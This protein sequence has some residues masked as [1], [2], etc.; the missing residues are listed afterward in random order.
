[1]CFTWSFIVTQ[2]KALVLVDG[3][4]SFRQRAGIAWHLI[5]GDRSNDPLF[6]KLLR[7]QNELA[8]ILELVR[9]VMPDITG[10]AAEA[11]A[12]LT[13]RFT[14]VQASNIALDSNLDAIQKQLATATDGLT[15]IVQQRNQLNLEL[16]ASAAKLSNIKSIVNAVD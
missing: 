1:M 11:V 2:S 6:S 5:R 9:G 4:D 14:T 12:K 15:A 8:T 3:T 7:A 13:D 16:N 10:T